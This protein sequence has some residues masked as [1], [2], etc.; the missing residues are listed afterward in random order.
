MKIE[1]REGDVI[2]TTDQIFFD[3]K[4]LVHPPD[5]IIAFPRFVPDLEADRKRGEVTYR[6]IYALSKRYALLKKSFPEY[7][8]YD[9]VFDE[10]LCEVPVEAV[11][12]HYRPVDR[13]HELRHSDQLEE[14]ED[15]ALQFMQLLRE[16]AKVPWTQLGISGSILVKLH[17][18]ASDIDPVVYGSKTCYKVYGALKSLLEDEKSQVRSYRSDELKKLFDFRSKDTVTSFEDFVR[19]ESRKVLQG[20]FMERDYFVRLVKDWNEVG[21]RYGTVRYKSAGYA[22]IRARVVDDSEMI[23]TPCCYRIEDVK[24]IDGT[25]VEPIEEI[26]SFRGRFCEQARNGETVIAQGKVERVQ[27]PSEREHYRLLLGNS[28]SDHMILV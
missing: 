12:R 1:A 6:K 10:H 27:K 2:E 4:G 22:R 15:Q 17:T 19:T 14:L 9:S 3:V 11:R 21:E 7:L 26:V 5:R 16:T 25:R 24:V 13:L 28:I 20:T 23:F 8:V 18:P